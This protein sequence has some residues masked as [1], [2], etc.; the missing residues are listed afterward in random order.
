MSKTDIY[1]KSL[2]FKAYSAN[3]LDFHTDTDF[4]TPLYNVWTFAKKY[5][6]FRKCPF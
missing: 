4:T 1:D 5:D 3:S 6:Y 2:D